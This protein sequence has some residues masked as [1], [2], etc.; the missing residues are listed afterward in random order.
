MP[1]C[2]EALP[3]VDVLINNL[4]VYEPKPFERITDDDWHSII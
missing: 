4:G 3:G 2:I 1:K